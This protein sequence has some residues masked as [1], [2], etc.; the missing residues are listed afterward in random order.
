MTKQTFSNGYTLLIGV[1]ADLSVTVLDA[2]A[3]RDILID[4]DRAAYSLIQVTQ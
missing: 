3:I 1:G 2:T 4:G